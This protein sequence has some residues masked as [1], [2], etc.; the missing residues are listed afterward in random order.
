MQDGESLK[1]LGKKLRIKAVALSMA[2]SSKSE[3]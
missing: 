3:F 2:L 1:K